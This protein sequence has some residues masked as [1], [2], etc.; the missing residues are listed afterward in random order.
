[1]V[2]K[3]K[4]FPILAGNFFELYDFSLYGLFS[5]LFS[6]LFFKDC[7]HNLTISFFVF[8]CGFLARPIGSIIFGYIGD[9]Y[10]RKKSI[11]LSTT[12]MA[13]SSFLI[14]FIPIDATLPWLKVLFVTM[15]ILCRVLQGLSMGGETGG[16]IVLLY[17]LGSLENKNLYISFLY[18][19]G[20]LGSLAAIFVSY[21]SLKYF[22]PDAAW[23]IA[24]F[25]NIVFIFF[26][27]YMRRTIS[28][29]TFF[30]KQQHVR[31]S[32]RKRNI[33]EIL[34]NMPRNICSIMLGGFMG[35]ISCNLFVNVNI[36]LITIKGI[37]YKISILYVSEMIFFYIVFV[38]FFSKISRYFDNYKIIMLS[39]IFT[40]LTS[41]WAYFL[42]Y[43]SYYICSFLLFS[44]TAAS[45]NPIFNSYIYKYFPLNWKYTGMALSCSIGVS[46][47]GGTFPLIFSSLIHLT[48][49]KIFPAIYLMVLSVLTALCTKKLKKLHHLSL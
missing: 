18:I 27:F 22:S 8:F 34:E 2:Y 7:E 6:N 15:F 4:I 38:Y 49:N 37:E 17:E 26:L 28:E 9:I 12:L 35:A 11:L 29:S 31:K 47:F 46:L 14:P 39:L 44:I 30:L 19:S 43:N 20:A 24:Y 33:F 10:G 25:I 36:Y 48:N 45:F 41:Y 1:M 16:A 5:I 3:K 40:F 13:F 32:V 21:I 42:L 23:R